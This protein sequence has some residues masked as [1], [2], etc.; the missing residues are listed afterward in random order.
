MAYSV[1][2]HNG[3]KVNIGHNNRTKQS[4]YTQLHIN[5]DGDFEIWKSENLKS[6]YTSLFDKAVQDYNEN[7][8]RNDRKIK[9]YYDKIES[10]KDKKNNPKLSYELIVA[11]GNMEESIEDE[12][13]NKKILKEY[14]EQ[15]EE[16]N[17]N[18]KV[19]NVAYHNDEVGVMHLHIDYIPIAHYE[20]GL[21]I[22]NSLN[23][24][25]NEMGF[26]NDKFSNTPIMRWQKAEQ[27]ALMNI[28]SSYGVETEIKKNAKREHFEKEEYIQFKK[29]E[30]MEKDIHNLKIYNFELEEQNEKQKQVINYN[31][32]MI[33][34]QEEIK[35]Q[36][37]K[38]IKKQEKEVFK[39]Q[40][41]LDNID[42]EIKKYKIENAQ[43]KTNFINY[44][45]NLINNFVGFCDYEEREKVVDTLTDYIKSVGD[46]IKGIDN[47]ENSMSEII[48]FVK[49]NSNVKSNAKQKENSFDFEL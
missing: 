43:Y 34:K 21:K 15:W 35:E 26:E 25:L 2:I 29:K 41:A 30:N 16:R 36:Q 10:G 33:N 14:F 7:Q 47:K 28:C 19:F 11:V 37:E 20:K 49:N 9:S 46:N 22:R 24:A 44:F 23:K 12:E 1:S 8:K 42:E 18:L 17:P 48:S 6:I 38:D 40:D 4:I 31:A 27:S 3:S 32:D 39:I 13:L 5:K 45:N